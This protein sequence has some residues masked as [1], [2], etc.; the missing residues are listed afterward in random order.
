MLFMNAWDDGH[1]KVWSK[2]EQQWKKFQELQ[3]VIESLKKKM[4]EAD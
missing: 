2:N 3:T 1:E 4:A